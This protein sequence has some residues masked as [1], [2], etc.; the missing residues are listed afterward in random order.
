MPLAVTATPRGSR[1]QVYV[2]PRASRT[3]IVG[4]HGDA[5]RVRLTAPPV[6][7]RANE[8]LIA[9]LAGTLKLPRSRIA[10]VGGETARTKSVEVEG[11]SPPDVAARFQGM[12]GD[13]GQT[14]T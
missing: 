2:Q 13:G 7:G 3:Q 9:L 8:A 5:L 4:L 14:K 12:V 1:F 10:I 6:E 11:L